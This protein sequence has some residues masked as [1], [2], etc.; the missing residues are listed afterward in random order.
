MGETIQFACPNGQQASGYL[1]V[2]AQGQAAPGVVVIQEWWGLN[3]QIKKVADRFASQG[4]RAL[5]PDLYH[6]RLAATPDEATHLMEGLDWGNATLQD[7]RGAVQHL[8]SGGGKVAVL[9][10]CMGGA[11]TLIAAAKVPEV[12]AAVCY[13]GIPPAE[14]ADPGQVRIPFQAHFANQDG[15]CTPAAVDDLDAKLR[16]AGTTYELYR[17]EAQHAFFNEERP[18]VY[19]AQA[20]GQSWQRSLAFLKAHL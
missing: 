6:G 7:V 17:Y 12:D 2:P 10:F 1:A 20:A 5:V 14:A 19:D 3:S 4:Y 9:G 13:Y 11:L 15:W 16:D 18:D 8:K